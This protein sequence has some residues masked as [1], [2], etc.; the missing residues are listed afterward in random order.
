[1]RAPPESLRPI[2]GAPVFSARSM[3]LQIFCALASDSDPPSTVKSWAKTYD[4]AAVDAARAGDEAIAIHHLLVHAE[5]AGAMT[6]QL[7][8]L[9][10]RAFVEQQIDTL[11]RR[12]LA[13][14]VL[15]L[16]APRTAAGFGIGAATA[17]LRETINTHMKS[18]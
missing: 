1:M 11:A 5:I 2:T 14:L 8:H 4:Q 12:E 15:P 17:H 10:E 16:H 3:I 18:R 6:N 13:F 7:V 9:F